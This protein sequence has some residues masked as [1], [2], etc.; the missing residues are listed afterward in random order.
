ML[1]FPNLGNLSS[2]QVAQP[3]P[4]LH[5]PHTAHMGKLRPKDR[6]E[7]STGHQD[8]A[9]ALHPVLPT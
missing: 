1:T 8:Q 2:Q 9:G 5:S 6:L 4:E 7:Q 3:L